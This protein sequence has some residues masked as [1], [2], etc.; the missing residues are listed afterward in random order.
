MERPDIQPGTVAMAYIQYPNRW[1]AAGGAGGVHPVIVVSPAVQC[2]RSSCLIVVPGTS[3]PRR[4]RLPTHYEP[5]PADCCCV[6]PTCF[7]CENV[8]QVD[9][10]AIRQVLG[11][12]SKL[13]Y[14]K[15][16]KCLLCAFHLEQTEW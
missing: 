12:V 10:G 11:R 13:E 9:K 14:M 5:D 4:N 6:V 1:D 7:H 15:L 16:Q 3:K 8:T 2:E